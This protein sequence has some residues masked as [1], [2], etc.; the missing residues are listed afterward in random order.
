MNF[1]QIKHNIIALF[2]MFNVF[3]NDEKKLSEK[4]VEIVEIKEINWVFYEF[5]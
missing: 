4:I 5:V 3:F 2:S 1:E